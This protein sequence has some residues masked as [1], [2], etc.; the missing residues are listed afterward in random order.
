[1]GQSSPARWRAGEAGC[2]SHQHPYHAGVDHKAAPM[3]V[4]AQT[5][6]VRS[7]LA[8][9]PGA[10]T[11]GRLPS[12]TWQERDG[13]TRTPSRPCWVP[14]VTSPQHRRVGITHPQ[15]QRDVQP[16]RLD[17]HDKPCVAFRQALPESPRGV[18]FPI[19]SAKFFTVGLIQL[20]S[21]EFNRMVIQFN[22]TNSLH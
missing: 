17:D 15:L 22:L 8:T 21:V 16:V 1:M 14:V 13:D 7:R 18:G 12:T 11:S 5:E 10:H 9:P 19:S 20:T 6:S 3:R 4:A 2:G